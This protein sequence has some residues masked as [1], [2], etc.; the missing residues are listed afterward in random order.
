MIKDIKSHLDFLVWERYNATHGC[1]DIWGT[2]D[3]FVIVG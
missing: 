2:A 3:P 1:N